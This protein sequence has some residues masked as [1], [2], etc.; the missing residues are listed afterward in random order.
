[1]LAQA[2]GAELTAQ[3]LTFSVDLVRALGGGYTPPA[4]PG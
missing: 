4:A 1:L 2:A 3:R